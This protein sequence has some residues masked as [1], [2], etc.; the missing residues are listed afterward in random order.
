MPSSVKPT[1]GARDVGR[2]VE[3]V[4]DLHALR[5]DR[6]EFRQILLDEVDD[7]QRGSVG[8]L[9]DRNVDGAAAVHE[10]VAGFDVGEVLHGADIANEDRAGAVG[11]YRHV[12]EAADV[13]DHRVDGHHRDHV[14]E[15]DVSGRADGVALGER[16][17]D[18]VGAHVVGAQ[19][20]RVGADDDGARRCRRTAAAPTRPGRS[21]TAAAP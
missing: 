21:R 20:V 11:P 6:L 13:A 17:H 16:R 1:N 18:L 4:A 12:A 2:L 10:R 14:A 19:P 8:A 15:A 5:Q 9:G 7:A 3:L